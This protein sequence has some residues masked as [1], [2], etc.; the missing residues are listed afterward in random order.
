MEKTDEISKFYK[1]NEL[2]LE[3][4]IEKYT[5]YVYSIVK[6]RVTKIRTE[7]AEEIISDVFLAV[8][9][10]RNKLDLNKSM[11]LYISGITKNLINKKLRNIKKDENI[12]EYDENLINLENLELKVEESEKNQIIL[13]ELENMNSED[14]DIFMYYY[15]YSRKIKEIAKLLNISESKTKVKLSRI[16]K[17]MRQALERKGYKVEK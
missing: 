3:K 4:V 6:A 5:A 12:T 1:N 11:S 13:K 16:R 7:D 9:N 17:K 2:E 15:Y 8:W 10:N 14:K